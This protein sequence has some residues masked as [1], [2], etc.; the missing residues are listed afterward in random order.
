MTGLLNPA[1]RRRRD[2]PPAGP[3]RSELP[4]PIRRPATALTVEEGA[5]GLTRRKYRPAKWCESAT[6]SR[7]APRGT[8]TPENEE[9]RAS[10]STAGVEAA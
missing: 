9:M 4:D 5:H 7:E 6:D 10:E 3:V 1:P 8:R 2:P